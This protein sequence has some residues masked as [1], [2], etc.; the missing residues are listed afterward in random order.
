[1]KGKARGNLLLT[2]LVIVILFFALSATVIIRLF[3]S[4]YA[5]SDKSEYISAAVMETGNWAE[6]LRAVDDMEALLLAEGFIL[7]EGEYVATAESGLD[8]AIKLEV[9]PADGGS[10]NIANIRAKRGAEIV[11]DIECRKYAPE[12]IE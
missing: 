10:M 7:V 8:L 11:C 6:R 4:A 3:I 12:V 1:M 9:Q 5:V 2:E